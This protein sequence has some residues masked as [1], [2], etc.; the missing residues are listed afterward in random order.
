[1]PLKKNHFVSNGKALVAIEKSSKDIEARVK[2]AVDAIG[3]FKMSK[4]FH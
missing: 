3:G 2:A 4:I 1:M